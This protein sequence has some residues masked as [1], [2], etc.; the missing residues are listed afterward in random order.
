MLKHTQ[1]LI[2]FIQASTYGPV[3]I[4]I[5]KNKFRLDMRLMDFQVGHYEK[6]TII[7]TINGTLLTEKWLHHRYIQLKKHIRGEWHIFHEDMLTIIPP[8]Y[9]DLEKIK[10]PVLKINKYNKPRILRENPI[11][12]VNDELYQKMEILWN[13]S[14]GHQK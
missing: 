1:G 14:V 11:F 13:K 10:F 3:K 7:R 8:T 5:V 4:G 9:E 2:Y 6:L 12:M